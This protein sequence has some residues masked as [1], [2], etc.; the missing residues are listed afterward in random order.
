MH[1]NSQSKVPKML[2]IQ[3]KVQLP[4]TKDIDIFYFIFISKKTLIYFIYYFNIPFNHWS[5]NLM[6]AFG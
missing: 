6:E 1:V 5:S 3:D 2:S 4:K